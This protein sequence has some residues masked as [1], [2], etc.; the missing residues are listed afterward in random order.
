MINSDT[1][2]SRF[3]QYYLEKIYQLKNLKKIMISKCIVKSE[4]S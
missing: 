1:I 4:I 2:E 3:S